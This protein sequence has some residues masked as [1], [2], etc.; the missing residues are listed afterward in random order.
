M[1]FIK[2]GLPIPLL[3]QSA[4]KPLLPLHLTMITMMTMMIKITMRMKMM[5]KTTMMM[6]MMRTMRKLSS[7][8]LLLQLQ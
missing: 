8:H 5:I 2:S 6:A 3:L 4:D 1:P 7:V